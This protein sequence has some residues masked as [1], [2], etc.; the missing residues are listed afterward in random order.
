MQD[1]LGR[2]NDSATAIR[3]L[4]QLGVTADDAA[5]AALRGWIAAQGAATIPLVA[6]AWKKFAKARP[7]WSAD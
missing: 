6:D 3:L 5:A 1:V 7:F 4:A 2:G